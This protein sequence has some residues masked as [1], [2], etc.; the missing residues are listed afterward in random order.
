MEKTPIPDG[1]TVFM[2]ENAVIIRRKLRGG[3]G[4][5]FLCLLGALFNFRIR[6]GAIHPSPGP[7]FQVPWDSLL[8]IVPVIVAGYAAV[9]SLVNRTDVIISADGV[10]A[11]STPLPWWGDRNVRAQEICGFV[12]R[13]GRRREGEGKYRLMYID[14]SGKERDLGS[15]LSSSARRSGKFWEWNRVR[16]G[17]ANFFTCL[18]A[19]GASKKPPPPPSPLPPRRW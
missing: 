14:R 9:C 18:A 5:G 3:S 7:G 19:G 12:Y 11:V 15:R 1:L 2:E 13:E 6:S 16:S 8:E 4:I 17:K 10:K